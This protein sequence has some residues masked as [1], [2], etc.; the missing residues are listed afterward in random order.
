[1]TSSC[2]PRRRRPNARS[3]IVTFLTA[4]SLALGGPTAVAAEKPASPPSPP[5]SSR[6]SP[7]EAEAAPDYGPFRQS[8][9]VPFTRQLDF[10]KP[11]NGMHVRVSLD[12]GPPTTFQ[13]DTGSVGIIV[14]ADEVPHV[15]PDAPEGSITYSSS[16]ISL[17]GVWTP[18]TVTFVDSKDEHGR[19]ATAVVPV[20]AAKE[21]KVAPGAVNT[22]AA[23]PTLNPKVHMF[24]VGFGRGKEAHPER[25]PFVNL[26][27]MRA[28]TMRRGYA[29]TRDGYTLGLS[30]AGVGDGYLFQKLKERPVA[31]EVAKLSPGLKDWETARGSVTVNGVRGP[32]AAVLLDTGLTNMMIGKVEAAPEPEVPAGTPVSVHLMGGRLN[33]TFKVGDAR[34]PVAPRRVTWVKRTDAATLNTGLRALAIYDYLYDADGGYLGLRPTAKHP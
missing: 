33:Y 2:N 26:K 21:R 30:A 10:D 15:A 34:D 3:T 18:V 5:A 19:P 28:G 8:N 29:I 27:E 11:L 22:G 14:G 12:G 4:A 1:M 6:A 7:S 9:H 13:V 20:L 32:D 25:N 17:V 24:G 23:K 16:G 31:P